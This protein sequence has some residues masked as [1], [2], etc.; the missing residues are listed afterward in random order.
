MKSNTVI[1]LVMFLGALFIGI[2][3]CYGS[4]EAIAFNFR[5]SISSAIS[6]YI[7]KRILMKH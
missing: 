6:A 7:S 3:S 5:S 2:Y 1:V 4:N